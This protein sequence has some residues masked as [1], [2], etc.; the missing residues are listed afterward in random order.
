MKAQTIVRIRK[1]GR[2]RGSLFA[3]DDLT[4]A[5]AAWSAGGVTSPLMLM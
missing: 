1:T 4:T 2:L 5:G 3:A